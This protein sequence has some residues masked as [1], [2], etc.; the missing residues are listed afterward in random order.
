MKYMSEIAY[1]LGVKINKD[2]SKKL[3]SLSQETYIKRIFERFNM[4]DCKPMI[5]SISKRQS[6]SLEMCLKTSE[7]QKVMA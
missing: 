7:E 1:I 6:L 5:T 3:L 4:S 2:R